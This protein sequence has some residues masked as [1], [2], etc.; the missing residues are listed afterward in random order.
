MPEDVVVSV[1]CEEFHT[2]AIA[3]ARDLFGWDQHE[4]PNGLSRRILETRAYIDA[5]QE[6]QEAKS[7]PLAERDFAEDLS[8][9]QKL[10]Q[11]IADELEIEEAERELA[12]VRASRGA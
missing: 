5:Y 11:E 12:K 8:P 9:I 10:V 3:A 2:R 1:Y 7:K 4:E 6:L